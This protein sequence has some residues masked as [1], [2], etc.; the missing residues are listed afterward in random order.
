MT[1]VILHQYRLSIVRTLKMFKVGGLVMGRVGVV[2]V[3][4]T[5]TPHLLHGLTVNL[6]LL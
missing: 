3:R 1:T 2:V 5:G 4:H 6:K